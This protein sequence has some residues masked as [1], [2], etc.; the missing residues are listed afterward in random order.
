M[1]LHTKYNVPSRW[2]YKWCEW[3]VEFAEN[4]ISGYWNKHSPK[5]RIFTNHNRLPCGNKIHQCVFHIGSWAWVQESWLLMLSKIRFKPKIHMVYLSNCAYDA[6]CTRRCRCHHVWR[7]RSRGSPHCEEKILFSRP[8]A[9]FLKPLSKNITGLRS[10][11]FVFK[12]PAFACPLNSEWEPGNP[13]RG[14]ELRLSSVLSEIRSLIP[15][16]IHF[17]LSP[18]D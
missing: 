16:F 15:V 1:N 11:L 14:L 7:W 10:E 5:W 12:K 8:P 6:A 2:R 3:S 17:S 13:G 18:K 4:D 9:R